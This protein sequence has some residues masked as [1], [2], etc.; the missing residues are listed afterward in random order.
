M[1]IPEIAGPVIIEP[2]IFFDD[3][4]IFFESYNTEL[5]EIIGSEYKFSQD[6]QS[7]SSSGVIRG[8]HFQLPPYEQGKL[9]RVVSGAALDVIVDIRRNSPTFGK[10]FSI[11]LNDIENKLFWVPPGFAHGFASLKPNTIF[12]YKCT[13]P[14]NKQSE[15]GIIYNDP[16]LNI[17]WQISN[18]NVSEKDMLLKRLKDV[19]SVF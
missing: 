15:S 9:V 10:Y 5:N 7:V 1:S 8:L 12:L 6:N 3:R 13:A 2:A 14:Y 4:G 11:V 16:D 18:P 17:D 19:E